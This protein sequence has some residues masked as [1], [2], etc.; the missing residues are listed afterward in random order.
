MCCVIARR[1]CL[2]VLVCLCVCMC[3]CSVARSVVCLCVCVRACVAFV[4][5]GAFACLLLRSNV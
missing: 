2:C 3:A 5:C 1:L 4:G